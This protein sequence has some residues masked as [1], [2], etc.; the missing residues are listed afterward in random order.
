[1]GYPPPPQYYPYRPPPQ[2]TPGEY[3]QAQASRGGSSGGGGAAAGGGAL[4]TLGSAYGMWKMADPFLPKQYTT[5]GVW[6]SIWNGSPSTAASQTVSGAS[7]VGAF[8]GITGSMSGYNTGAGAFE[9]ISGSMSGASPALGATQYGTAGGEFSGISGS[10]NGTSSANTAA[11]GYGNALQAAGALYGAYNLADMY[12]NRPKDRGSGVTSG[13]TSG[14]AVGSYV[15]GPWGAAIGAILGGVY[16]GAVLKPKNKTNLE[17]RRNW[18]LANRGY[19]YITEADLADKKNPQIRT[20]LAPDFQGYDSAGKYV[21]NRFANSRKESDLTPETILNRTQGVGQ[22]GFAKEFG[23]AWM[24]RL[25]DSQR[26][27][28]IQDALNRGLVTEKLGST[29]LNADQALMRKA[30]YAMNG[31]QE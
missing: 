13:A 17:Q 18:K 14:A 25:N 2:Y 28:I 3:Q 11:S 20:D 1:M 21:N 8:D 24:E 27:S 10:M 16:G 22:A 9:G 23:N 5:S 6:D 4:G 7:S 15:G 30:L 26:K 31:I 12:S 29:F 19:K